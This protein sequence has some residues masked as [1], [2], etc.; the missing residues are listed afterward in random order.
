MLEFSTAIEQFAHRAKP[1]LPEENIRRE[2]GKAFV[3][4]LE[5]PDIQI[6][7]LLGGQKTVKEAFRQALK[8]H[9]VLLAASP[10]K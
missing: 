1:A 4:V 8:L 10:H 7:V 9:A 2:A 3:D 5:D 6:Q